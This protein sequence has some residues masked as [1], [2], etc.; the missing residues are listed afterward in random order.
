MTQPEKTK[1][2]SDLMP[3]LTGAA[4]LAVLAGGFLYWGGYAFAGFVAAGMMLMAMEL[5]AIVR[6]DWTVANPGPA[7]CGLF[8]GVAV[9]LVPFSLWA[10]MGAFALALLTASV[11]AK[12]LPTAVTGSGLA[13][14]VLAGVSVVTLRL[15]PGGLWLV[16]WV[17][18]CVV[19]ADVGGYFFGKRFQG[20]KFWP[21]V[22]PKKTWSGVLGGLL[23]TLV[24]ALIYGLASDGSVAVFLTLGAVIAVVSVVGDLLESALKR[25]YG[26]KDAGRILPGH[27]GLLDRFDGMT[28]V[29]IVF[30]PFSQSFD[31]QGLLE[32]SYAPPVLTGGSL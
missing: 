27:G 31:L 20:P 19:A 25:H 13:L 7:L 29:M 24:V 14:I 23:L 22:S 11:F 8:C 30:F 26:V 4:V 5:L 1:T 6:H 17:I 32:V 15:E 3:R 16:L 9:L 18:L 12:R 10:S 2:Y 28:A 21:A